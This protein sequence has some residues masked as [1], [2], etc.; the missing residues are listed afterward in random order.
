MAILLA[1]TYIVAALWISGGVFYWI[2]RRGKWYPSIVYRRVESFFGNLCGVS[3]LLFFCWCIAWFLHN[4]E[5]DADCTRERDRQYK[6][7]RKSFENT[8]S[9]V[10]EL[11]RER[12]R[13]ELELR[14]DYDLR[15]ARMIEELNSNSFSVTDSSYTNLPNIAFLRILVL[16]IRRDINLIRYQVGEEAQYSLE[17]FSLIEGG[18][19]QYH[20]DDPLQSD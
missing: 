8:Y 5:V 1:I 14:L 16:D 10:F 9:N 13:R 15:A 19:V 6:I 17:P 11:L 12:N 18:A 2:F 20:Q 4:I 7:A 3:I